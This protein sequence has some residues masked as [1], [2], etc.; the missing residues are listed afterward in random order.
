MSRLH[1]LFLF[2]LFCLI[3]GAIIRRTKNKD[4]AI[5][6]NV[7]NQQQMIIE[8]RRNPRGVGG[9]AKGAQFSQSDNSGGVQSKTDKSRGT[10]DAESADVSKR[11]GQDLR[12]LDLQERRQELAE[13]AEFLIDTNRVDRFFEIAANLE[14]SSDIILLL[15]EIMLNLMDQDPKEAAIWLNEFNE[16]WNTYNTSKFANILTPVVLEISQHDMDTAYD[17]IDQLEDIKTRESVLTG[18]AQ[19][20]IK[21]DVQKAAD[22]IEYFPP[23]DHREKTLF[24]LGF[25]WSQMDT[26][27]A[28]NWIEGLPEDNGKDKAI[29]GLVNIWVSKDAHAAANWAI[30][31]QDPYTRDIAVSNIIETWTYRD[32]KLVSEWVVTF[33]AGELRTDSFKKTIELWAQYH[34]ESAHEWVESIDD[35]KLQRIGLRILG[36]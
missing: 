24:K 36:D 12:S 20:W 3:A 29:E 22:W 14:N 6:S 16:R 19:S 11:L 7:Q 30:Q 21:S 13:V 1:F 28:A 18:A 32:P 5:Q 33:P 34:P 26:E 27:S 17:L 35:K 23:G 9:K 10:I 25:Q 8:K 2:L 31:L 4:V 15:S